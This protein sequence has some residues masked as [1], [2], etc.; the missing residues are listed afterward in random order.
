MEFLKRPLAITDTETTGLDAQIHE[1]IEIGLIVVEQ[2]KLRVI[3][4]FEVKVKPILIKTAV[5]K[6]LAVNGYNEKDWRKAWDL[7]EA[8]EIYSEKTKNAIF[9]AQNA[10]SDWSFINEAFKKTQVEDLMDY[11]RI[12]LF[13]LGWSKAP[14]LPG[15]TKFSLAS[16]CKYFDIEPEPLPH[17]AIN[18]AKKA[19]AVLKRLLQV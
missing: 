14:K 16:M 15:L 8:I 3:D 18:G 6:A 9:V 4:K 12:D 5:K 19:L 10:F 11:H 2:P 7:K 17:R 13:T 1:I